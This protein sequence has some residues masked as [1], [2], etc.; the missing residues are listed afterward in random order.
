MVIGN[1]TIRYIAYEG[2]AWKPQDTTGTGQDAREMP[3][4]WSVP[5][6]WLYCLHSNST[7]KLYL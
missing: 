5:A 3:N 6:Y 1:G 2:Y 7:F 4:K